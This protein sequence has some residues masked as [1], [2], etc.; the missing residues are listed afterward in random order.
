MAPSVRT[1]LFSDVEGSTELLQRAGSRY[2]ELLGRHQQIIRNA[3]APE[4]IW[5]P[6]L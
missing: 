2:P 3:I 5:A 1:M 6:K 4:K